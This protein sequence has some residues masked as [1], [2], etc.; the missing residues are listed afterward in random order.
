[1]RYRSQDE[2]SQMEEPAKK[3]L[4]DITIMLVSHCLS[5]ASTHPALRRA[6]AV[7]DNVTAS[8]HQV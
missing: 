7:A 5:P 3:S 8:S 2:R 1:V 6:V 4:A